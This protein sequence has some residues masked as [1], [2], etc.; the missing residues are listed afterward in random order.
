MENI[1]IRKVG[2]NL[3]ATA[4]GAFVADEEEAI[5]FGD[6]HAAQEFC[7]RHHFSDVEQIPRA[8]LF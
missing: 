8:R 4:D 2:G 1:V 3:F 6:S 5:A 7:S